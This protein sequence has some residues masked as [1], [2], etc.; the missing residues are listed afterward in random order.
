MVCYT[1]T[2]GLLSD[3]MEIVDDVFD[4][5]FRKDPESHGHLLW[6]RYS[7]HVDFQCRYRN[8]GR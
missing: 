3:E 1:A 4:D 2:L 5:I 8:V 7:A 6:Q